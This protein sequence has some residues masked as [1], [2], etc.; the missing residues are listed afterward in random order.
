MKITLNKLM[1]DEK[2][3]ALILAMILMLVGS[4]IIAPLLG[5][6]STGLMAGQVFE[7]R[8]DELY[9]ADAGVEDALHKIVNGD[10]SLPD[11]VGA[12]WT[13]PPIVV[14][15]KVVDVVIELG[16]DVE[17]FLEELLDE[18]SGPHDDWT[19]IT[20]EVIPGTYAITITYSGSASVKRLNGVGAW[21]QGDYE[22]VPGSASGMTDDYPN[23]SF[24]QRDNFK[25]G[26]AFIWEWGPA[27][28]NKPV[29]GTVSGVYERTLTFEF[30]PED[31][32]SLYFSW[33]LG[34]SAD[35]GVVPSAQG[36]GIWKVTTTAIDSATGKQTEVIA[37]VSSNGEVVPYAVGIN[38]WDIS[39]Q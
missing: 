31:I 14:N 16:E 3:Q 37:Y 35:I 1:R 13:L 2:G 6:M 27:A 17:S 29:F 24:E 15:G 36:F 28:G 34:A 38:T 19:V 23:Y 11:T 7:E 30:T 33:I 8:M 32:P 9:A 5:F 39:L 21:L 26:T 20:D 4:L 12:T 10:A 25:Q 22:Y 18:D